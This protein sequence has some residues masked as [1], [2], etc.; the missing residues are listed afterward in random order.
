MVAPL[1]VAV[2][3]VL[4]AHTSCARTTSTAPDSTVLAKGTWG[5]ENIA[6]T[7]DDKEVHVEFDCAA[8]SF[9]QPR[10][11]DGGGRFQVDGVYAKERGGPI[12]EG[13][14]VSARYSGT[15]SGDT[16]TLTVTLLD[17]N[18]DIGPF[19]VTLGAQPRL[20]KCV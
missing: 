17:A 16:L 14:G 7:V 13:Q 4:L 8:G 20:R 3:F 9:V 12:R 15:L 11:L 19:T 1:S 18:E 2:V 6:L 10:S 5:G